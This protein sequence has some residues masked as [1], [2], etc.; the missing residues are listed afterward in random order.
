MDKGKLKCYLSF[1]LILISAYC[2]F[3]L[4]HREITLFRHSPIENKL[5]DLN[6]NETTIINN[7]IR[8]HS[9]IYSDLQYQDYDLYIKDFNAL[10]KLGYKK[11]EI[12]IIFQHL[13]PSEVAIIISKGEFIND[14]VYYII[15]PFFYIDN[16]DRY[17]SFKSKNKNYPYEKIINYVNMNLDYDFYQKLIV[18]NKP[19]DT[20]VLVNK[21]YKL[22]ENY[23]PKE[24]VTIVSQCSINN[25]LLTVPIVKDA[26][27]EM[28]NDIQSLGLNIK[29][30]SAYRSYE[31][32]EILYNNY[33]ER[34]GVKDADVSSAK[35]GH[36]EHQTGLSIDIYNTVLPFNQ[37][38]KSNE[39]KWIKNNAHNYGFI[40][41]YPQNREHITGYKYEP[42]H[43]RYVGNEVATYLYKHN[44]TLDEYHARFLVNK[45]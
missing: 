15:E 29:I 12:N 3:F 42:W 16:F 20:L 25:D 21:Y 18:I 23:V 24:L 34:E 39:Y 44:I 45:P 28:C 8:E 5:K 40:V 13:R 35:P 43:L 14:L 17:I 9:Q 19:D 26:F 38:V 33:V 41:R 10:K 36:S 2:A 31:T 6:Y 11:D 4:I 22:P 27:E 1:I 37:F 7:S 30:I 32:Q